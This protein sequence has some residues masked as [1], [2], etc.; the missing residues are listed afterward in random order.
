MRLFLPAALALSLTP[1]LAGP[2]PLA[3]KAADAAK[4][5]HAN[6]MNHQ[7]ATSHDPADVHLYA[8]ELRAKLTRTSPKGNVRVYD[9]ESNLAGW[10]GRDIKVR[11]VKGGWE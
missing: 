7:N 8:S 3:K 1:G 9:I 5:K 6:Q 11:K 2:L 10:D 4:I